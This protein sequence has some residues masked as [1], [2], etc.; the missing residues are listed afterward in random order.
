MQNNPEMDDRND[1]YKEQDKKRDAAMESSLAILARAA[2]K[3]CV[4][5][6]PYFY[7]ILLSFCHFRF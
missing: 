7:R 1:L 2:R 5:P 6:L 4:G 3:C